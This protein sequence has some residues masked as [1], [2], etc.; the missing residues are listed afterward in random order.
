M[1]IPVPDKICMTGESILIVENE[2]IIALQLTK[3]LEKNGYQIAGMTAY[4]EDAVMMAEKDHPDLICMDIEL[5]GKMDG[6]EAAR[7]IHEHADIPIIYLTAFSDSQRIARAKVTVPYSYIVKPF[8]E[9]ELLAS[10]EMALYRHT[11][12]QKLKESMQRYRAIVDNAAEGILLVSCGTGLILEANPATIRLLGYTASE[13]SCKTVGN[14]IATPDGKEGTW[15]E[16][17]CTL[18]SWS[19]EVQLRCR[20]GSLRDVELTSSIIH[21]KDSPSLSCIVAHDVTER[22]RGEIALR[23]AHRKINLLS[24]IT[25]HDILNQITVLSGYLELSGPAVAGTRLGEYVNKEKKA[26]DAIRRLINF[27]KDYEEIGQQPPGWYRVEPIIDDLAKTAN[28]SG[29]T[30]K[31]LL[32]DL[33]LYTDPLLERVFYNLLDTTIRHGDQAKTIT[34]TAET[35]GTA[36]VIRWEDDG[37]GFPDSE[38]EQIF[39]R[40][41]RKDTSLGLFL[42]RE[43]LG[44]TGI[45]IRE[46]GT[47]GSGTRFEMVVPSGSFRYTSNGLR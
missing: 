2:G 26:V 43:I 35:S 14:I 29:I 16:R 34:M 32:G 22:K 40:N 39:E 19:G 8:N 12:D 23:E 20:D 3:L 27:T 41:F 44:L 36:L 17:I 13:L 1:R 46:R 18:G 42:V 11:V 37:A 33:E 4:G 38:K 47:F 45:T 9:P 7:K 30:L 21:R 24:S 6:I 15:E 10:V 5:M 25:R 31:S 28:P